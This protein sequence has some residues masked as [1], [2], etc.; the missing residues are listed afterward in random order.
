MGT[1]IGFINANLLLRDSIYRQV[2]IEIK[3]VRRSP[4]L[5]A[6]CLYLLL[7]SQ[8]VNAKFCISKTC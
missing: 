1:S 7:T 8:L 6:R 2:L 3:M 4:S 5:A